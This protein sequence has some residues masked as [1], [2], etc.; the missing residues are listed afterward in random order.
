LKFKFKY[1]KS[2]KKIFKNK[3]K[4]FYINKAK[5][6]Y[7][8]VNLMEKQRILREAQKI[9]DNPPI[10][11]FAVKDFPTINPTIMEIPNNNAVRIIMK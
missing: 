1:F 11:F 6:R 7:L 5:I 9:G 4:S 2:F 10:K 8:F 3:F